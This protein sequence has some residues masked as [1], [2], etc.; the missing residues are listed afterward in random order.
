MVYSLSMAVSC[1]GQEFQLAE[2]CRNKN[3]EIN[4]M[5]NGHAHVLWAVLAISGA[6]FLI[7]IVAGIMTNSTALL[8]EFFVYAF[9]LF[10]LDRS[11]R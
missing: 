5:R 3:C 6:M 11:A 9:S 8:A 10:V 4:D 2:C 1:I 7:E